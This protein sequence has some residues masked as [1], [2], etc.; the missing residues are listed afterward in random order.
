MRQ[1]A[2]ACDAAISASAATQ[3]WTTFYLNIGI[4]AIP[5][6]CCITKYKY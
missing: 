6:R 4:D 1:V 3:V 5:N 2:E